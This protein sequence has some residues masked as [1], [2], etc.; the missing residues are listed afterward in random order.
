VT[1][2][3][4]RWYHHCHEFVRTL[5]EDG[6]PIDIVAV[7]G[8]IEPLA[9]MDLDPK[10]FN[11]LRRRLQAVID[12]HGTQRIVAIAHQDCAWY[13][14]RTLEG[15]RGDARDQQVDDLRRATAVLQEMVPGVTVDMYYAKLNGTSP[16]QVVFE[17]VPN[18]PA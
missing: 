12:A 17:S 11:F 8:G 10:D 13:Q 2:V 7:P 16:P 14:G 6:T 4:G 1:C 15:A 3:D 18:G 5:L 9:L